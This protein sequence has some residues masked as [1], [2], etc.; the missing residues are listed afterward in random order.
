MPNTP[1]AAHTSSPG[2]WLRPVLLLLIG[3]LAVYRSE[4]AGSTRMAL[5][6]SVAAESAQTALPAQ[7]TPHP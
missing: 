4:D 1:A 7:A 5:S 3:L 2:R 6:S